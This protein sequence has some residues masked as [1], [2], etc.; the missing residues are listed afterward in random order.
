MKINRNVLL[1]PGPT[2]TTDTVKLALVGPDMCHREKDF[3]EVTQKL[4]KDLVKIVHG[5]EE[6]H[7][8]VL[9]AGSGTVN[10]DAVINSL[11]PKDK[12][13]LI[14]HNGTYSARALEIAQYY[15][16]PYIELKLPYTESVDPKKV[17]EVLETHHDIHMVYMT[18]HE[19][20]SGVLNDIRSVGHL[21]HQHGAIFVTDA[22]SSYALIPMDME[23][24]NIDFLV[25]SAQKGIGAMTGLSFVIGKRKLIEAS[26]D[27]PKRSYYCNLFRQYD[28]FEKHGELQFTPP[29]Q[30]IYAASQA[31]KEYF[32]EGEEAKW[33][34]HQKTMDA[35]HEGVASLGFKEV[36]ER[37]HQSGLVCAIA[38]PDDP[39][40]DFMKIHDYCYER[41]FTLFPR[42]VP[43]LNA[44]R[45]AVLGA[46]DDNDI[47]AFFKVLK[48]ALLHNK[49]KIPVTYAPE[50]KER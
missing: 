30:L 13:L 44:F 29:V 3:M 35:V 14:I 23:K 2:T 26:K 36:I 12:K 43:K 49:I 45:V 9:F 31:I 7:V 34:R 48:D 40:W 42:T 39:N 47:H 32:A 1:N 38:M 46:I 20:G 37:K 33:L 16:L 15:Q 4:T 8:A 19:T 10:M 24:D 28:F 27:Y 6:D 18:H 5:R 11:L 41:G 17:E 21:S 25:A 50:K 22:T